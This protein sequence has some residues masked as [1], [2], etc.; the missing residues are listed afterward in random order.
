MS[1]TA[2]LPAIRW[3]QI[4][5]LVGLDLAILISWIAYHE[6]QPKLLEQFKFTE[7]TLALA[8][9]QGLI[10]AATPPVARSRSSP[11]FRSRRWTCPS[12]PRW[13]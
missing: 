1:T 7:F 12:R 9:L 13:P 10:L 8:V 3:P 5:S 6:Y 11:R 4:L 2:H